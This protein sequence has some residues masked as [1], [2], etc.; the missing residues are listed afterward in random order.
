M[1]C[2]SCD[3]ILTDEEATRRVKSSGEFLDLCNLCYFPIHN[4][5]ELV[6]SAKDNDNED[7]NE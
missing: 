7:T 6:P 5:V 3:S 4:E 2:L 1:K